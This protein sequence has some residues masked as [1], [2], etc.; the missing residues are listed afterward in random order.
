MHRQTAGKVD[1][2]A[3]ARR[4]RKVRWDF[5]RADPVAEAAFH[6]RYAACGGV[7]QKL[8]DLSVVHERRD[9]HHQAS[10][11]R[12]FLGRNFHGVP[13]EAGDR[14]A[15]S[16]WRKERLRRASAFSLCICPEDAH[17]ERPL[18][19]EDGIQALPPHTHASDEIVDRDTVVAFRP[20]DL[21]RFVGRG[22]S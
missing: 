2:L 19:S 10:S 8:P 17:E 4:D 13:Q 12:P 18:V 15:K 7:L 22:I 16:R 3:R 21:R 20:K 6:E 5:S 1:N 11:D 14:V 9:A